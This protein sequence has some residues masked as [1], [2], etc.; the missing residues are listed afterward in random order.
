MIV[1]LNAKTPDSVPIYRHYFCLA[2]L[3]F[4]MMGVPAFTAMLNEKLFNI[5]DNASDPNHIF[6]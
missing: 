6:L 2:R 3:T 4:F 5:I 1:V